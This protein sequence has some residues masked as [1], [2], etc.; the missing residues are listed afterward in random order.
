MIIY[1]N[2]T[3]KLALESYSEKI[4]A[5]QPSSD[6]PVPQPCLYVC[7][8]SF[9]FSMSW[10]SIRIRIQHA[11]WIR[12]K[13]MRIWN[14]STYRYR[15]VHTSHRIYTNPCNLMP[16]CWITLSDIYYIHISLQYVHTGLNISWTRIIHSFVTL[17]LPLSDTYIV[18]V[19][20]IS[21]Q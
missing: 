17:Q 1:K 11:D 5:P 16:M 7:I 3:L 4:S 2:L 12:I 10:T 9:A 13:S 8:S 18:P 19:H 21:L 6:F 20:N 15:T 14:T